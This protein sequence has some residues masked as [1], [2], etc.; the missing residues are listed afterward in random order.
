MRCRELSRALLLLTALGCATAY[1]RGIVEGPAG[2]AVPGATVRLVGAGDRTIAAEITDAHGC[3][4]IQRT[5]PKGEQRFTLE[6]TAEGY[7]AARLDVPLQPPIFLARLAPSS[8][9]D[10]SGIR[11]TTA[12]ER[13]DRWEPECIPLFAGGGAQQLSPH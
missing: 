7:K 12:A 8:S 10:E 13:R 2:A 5:A 3:F 1:T 9:R 6:I 11:A 4:F